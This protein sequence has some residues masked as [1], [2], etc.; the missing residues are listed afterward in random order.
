MEQKTEIPRWLWALAGFGGLGLLV[1]GLA[2]V[3]VTFALPEAFGAAGVIVA[4]FGLI[5]ATLGISLGVAG[6]RGWRNAPSMRFYS[7]WT[8]AVLLLGSIVT[9]ISGSLMPVQLQGHALFAPFHFLMITLPGLL[10]LSVVTLLIGRESALSI[11]RTVLALASGAS[12]VVLAIPVEV[13]GLML[14]GMLSV[15]VAMVFPGGSAEVDRLLTLVQGWTVRP[16]TSEAEILGVVTSPVVLLAL[17]LTLSVVTPLVEELSKTLLLGLFGMW[18]KP[19]APVAFL[20][21]A[22]CGLGFAWLEGVSNGAVGLGGVGGWLGSVGVRLFATAM[23]VLTSGLLGLGWG[24]FWRGRRWALPITYGVAVIFHGLWNLNVIVSV[25]GLGLAASSPAT[26]GM[27][28]TLGV[29]VQLALVLLA[30][31]ALIVIPL[32]LRKALQA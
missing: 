3:S 19:I 5:A 14:S 26:G 18:V 10:L 24:W 16:P 6:L 7:R 15:A 20:W 29:V 17:T 31:T 23:H 32:A 9:A 28:V 11:R 27:L 21:G 1:L 22:A 4:G 8:W 13:I 25:G 12:G 30:T 2:S